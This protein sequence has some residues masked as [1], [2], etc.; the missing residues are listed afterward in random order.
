MSKTLV[1]GATGFVGRA[2]TT[3]LL[4]QDRE[5]RVLA[6]HPQHRA[7]HG[8]E[9]EIV[10]GDLTDAASLRSALQDCSRLFHVAAD[11]RLW[12]P[13]PKAMYAVNI[14]GT[15]SLL[16][17]ALELGLERVVYTSTVGT[18]GN[19]G[20]GTPGTEDTPVTLTEM[21]GHYKKSKFLAEQVALDFSRQG[22]PLVIVNPSTPVGPW[23]VRPTPTGQVIV[24][25]LK[26]RMPA[27]LDSGLNL[28]HVRDVA[29]GH[30]LAEAKGRIGEKY[31]LGNQ[32][33]TLAEILGLLA[34]ISGLSA[35]RWRLPY[36]PVLGL[37]YVNEFWSTWIT[38]RPPRVPLTAVKMAKK[39]MYFDPQK[40]VREL[41]LP[42]TPV[43]AALREAVDWFRAQ[44]YV[45]EN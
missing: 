19:P 26:G 20:D 6:R 28:V 12:V 14:E 39:I 32:N 41:G 3:E 31:I 34:K 42:Q 45:K 11:Y 9:V 27:F 23:D 30:I 17:T 2:V 7:L 8:L 10:R 5:V 37:A 16:Q 43:V 22:L 25:F 1:T 18:L 24:D 35:P 21:V 36:Y 44:G 4:A 33:M 38:R 15:R 13:D 29:R 40:A